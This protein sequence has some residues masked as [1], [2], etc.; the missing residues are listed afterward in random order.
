MII[1]QCCAAECHSLPRSSALQ[2]NDC[3]QLYCRCAYV[4]HNNMH[5]YYDVLHRHIYTH[6]HAH[7]SEE[8]ARL[9]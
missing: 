2:A 4:K 8:G 7:E 1:F 9:V 6:M 5:Y 3:H